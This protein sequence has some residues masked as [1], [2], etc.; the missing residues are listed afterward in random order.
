M[1]NKLK[2]D[3]ETVSAITESGMNFVADNT[4]HIERSDIYTK[5]KNSIKT[6]E[7]IRSKDDYL[8]FVEAKSSFP[9]PNNPESSEKFQ[10][11]IDD[12]CDKFT[13]SL[14]L[15]ASIAIGANGQLPS[16]FKPAV[17]VSLNFILVINNFELRWCV[18]IE[19]ALINQLSKSKCIAKIWKPNIFVLNNEMALKQNLTY[20]Q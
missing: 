17:K 4:F 1:K 11:A 6:V 7:F 14:N 5:L 3:L 2:K 9:N 8:L 16:D 12:I 15:Y 19:K 18:P 20:G 10:S 13:H